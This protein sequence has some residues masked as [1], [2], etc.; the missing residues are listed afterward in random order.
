MS[1]CTIQTFPL[2]PEMSIH[3]GIRGIITEVMRCY[4]LGA[5]NVCNL[6]DFEFNLRLLVKKSD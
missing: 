5:M 2:K 3:G 4:Y 1:V 6:V